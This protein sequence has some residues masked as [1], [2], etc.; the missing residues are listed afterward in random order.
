MRRQNYVNKLSKIALS[1]P[2][3]GVDIFNFVETEVSRPEPNPP[4][5]IGATA[6]TPQF[7]EGLGVV[8]CNFG[9]SPARRNANT[10]A[11]RWT[12]TT[13]P[14]PYFI[15]V[16][17]QEEEGTYH[18]NGFAD[19]ERIFVVNETITEASK[20]M[21]IKEA[22]WNIGVKEL[23]AKDLNIT[24]LCFM[25]MDTQFVDQMWSTEVSNSLDT[26][27]CVSPHMVS[28]YADDQG[29]MP[30]GLVASVGYN[31]VVN[32]KNYGFQGLAFACTL[33]FYNNRLNGHIAHVCTGAGDT[34]LWYDIAGSSAVNVVPNGIVNRH[35]PPRDKSGMLP[36]P[37]M[38]HSNQVLV[39]RDH[40][41][42]KTRA[43]AQKH[44]ILKRCS[45]NN[46]DTHS[47]L[48]NGM[49][50]WNDNIPGR[51][52]SKVFPNIMAKASTNNP[53]TMAEAMNIY[54]QEAVE[55]YGAITPTYPLIVVC[56]LRSGG[57][58]D[59]RHVRWLARQF[60]KKCKTPHRFVCLSDI[61]IEGIETLPLNLSPSQALGSSVQVEQ[62]KNIWPKN[63][64]VLTCDLDTVLHR[65][66]IAHRCPEDQFFMLRE[67][68]L[69]GNPR[70]TTV[71]G[72]GLTYFRGNFSFIY[73]EYVDLIEQEEFKHPRYQYI[74]I[75]EFI[76]SRLRKNNI[77]PLSIE[78]HFC[79]RYWTSR[80]NIPQEASMLIFPGHPKPWDIVNCN[81][82]PKLEEC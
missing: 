15:I 48:E 60:S 3:R 19:N 80:S 7:I 51:L 66:F 39:H 73:S 77:Q 11:L 81:S 61:E 70:V 32:P 75:Q 29:G 31:R 21:F 47:F 1:Y 4:I 46:F 64:S 56:V 41:S 82:I 6:T 45:Y 78:P 14:K 59:A 36:T 50:V 38:G 49:P 69:W 57:I 30:T 9:D 52:M 5:Q 44:A 53:Y 43:Y 74:G 22:L 16:D 17:A 8:I 35:A 18:Y 42:K 71:W 37:K 40:G 34:Y 25:D 20:N 23:L 13:T 62:Y 54:E 72:S 76:V 58:Y 28:Y 26:Y 2:K 33:D 67:Y 10:R 27:D 12:L 68:D 65:P 79:C 24:K 63:A 55:E